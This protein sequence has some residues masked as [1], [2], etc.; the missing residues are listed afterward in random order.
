M[1]FSTI[2]I[3]PLRHAKP[4]TEDKHLESGERIISQQIMSRLAGLE[5]K[6]KLEQL[7]EGIL[8]DYLVLLT[9]KSPC[10]GYTTPYNESPLQGHYH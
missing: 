6:N 7:H 2:K 10:E 9:T 4:M 1:K 5:A 3:G 8:E